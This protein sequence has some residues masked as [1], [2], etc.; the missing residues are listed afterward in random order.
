M[1]ITT[2][3][4]NQYEKIMYGY[5]TVRRN[6]NEMSRP[7]MGFPLRKAPPPRIPVNSYRSNINT[8]LEPN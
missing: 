2:T 1:G 7:L 5:P 4:V 6:I 8:D 3:S